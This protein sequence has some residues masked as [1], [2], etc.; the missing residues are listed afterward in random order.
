PSSRKLL[1]NPSTPHLSLPFN[2]AND[3]RRRGAFCDLT[4]IVAD[5][6]FLA[7]RNV[8]AGASA[9]F[10][11]LLGS[12][13]D[14]GYGAVGRVVELPSLRPEVFAEVLNFVYS[15]SANVLRLDLR[16]ELVRAGKELGISFLANLPLDDISLKIQNKDDSIQQQTTTLD[17]KHDIHMCATPNDN[18]N[19]HTTHTS[20]RPTWT[21]NQPSA[22]KDHE[23][24]H[25]EALVQCDRCHLPFM[26]QYLLNV[27]PCEAE[28]LQ[29]TPTGDKCSTP[30]PSPVSVSQVEPI[31]TEMQIQPAEEMVKQEEETFPI[32]EPESLMLTIDGV[33]SQQLPT[34][35][36]VPETPKSQ[37]R[38]QRVLSSQDEHYVRMNAGQM[39]YCCTVCHRS[40]VQLTSLKRHA[41]VHSWRK[42]YPCHY[43]NRVFALAEYR[44]KHEVW[45]TDER[46]YQCI[47]CAEA[48]LTYHFLRTHQRTAHGITPAK[49]SPSGPVV[50]LYRLLPRQINRRFYRLSPH[51]NPVI[52]SLLT[53]TTGEPPILIDPHLMPLLP[54]TWYSF[55]RPQKDDRLNQPSWCYFNRPT[56]T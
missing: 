27:H 44:T 54:V 51:E 5:H 2:C 50:R 38:I 41:N 28:N 11:Q 49:G 37:N 9:R 23:V 12:G 17:L 32:P 34:N 47:F 6:K 15:A 55:F 18:P 53:D 48:F 45:H 40:Y 31:Q 29:V 36:V 56:R 10:R 30:R 22:F 52:P 7:H 35:T 13:G 25:H 26:S 24:S 21:Q 33:T 46:R 20:S 39:L 3:Q 1:N 4:V 42:K 8:L 19:S 14:K 16:T 43:C